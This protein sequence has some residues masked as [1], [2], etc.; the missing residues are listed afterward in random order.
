MKQ[1]SECVQNSN[2]MSCGD[3]DDE[4]DMNW[5]R[6]KGSDKKFVL[7]GGSGF[8]EVLMSKL[9]SIKWQ[10]MRKLNS[11]PVTFSTNDAQ[12]VSRN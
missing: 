11:F 9:M 7:E 12:T 8:V 1:R 6:H 2:S 3:D 5:S 10:Q 4:C